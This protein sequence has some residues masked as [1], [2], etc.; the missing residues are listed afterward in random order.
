MMTGVVSDSREARIR[1]SVRAQTGQEHEIEAVIDTGFN[2]W[3]TL[4]PTLVTGLNLVW[5]NDVRA[6][7]GDDTETVFGVYEATVIWDG[8]PR[9]VAAASVGTTPL[10]GMSLLEG[11]D[12][13]TRGR[14][15]RAVTIEAIP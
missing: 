8:Q 9:R 3:L 5:Q 1:V 15:G 7:L 4:P 14:I 10:V 12:L 2:G 6:T 13:T 11:F